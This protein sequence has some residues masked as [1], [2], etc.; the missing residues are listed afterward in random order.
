MG[1]AVAV[2]CD[3]RNAR[4]YSRAVGGNARALLK[5]LSLKHHELSVLIT[6]D[7]AIRELNRRFRGKDQATDVLSFP[8]IEDG[9][10]SAPGAGGHYQNMVTALGD[11][12]ISVDTAIRQASSLGVTP[13]TRMRTLLIHGVLHLLGYDHEKSRAEARRMF[14]LERELAAGL[15]AGEKRRSH[16]STAAYW[17]AEH[18]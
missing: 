9:L 5:L 14:L 8:Q 17:P 13:A 7:S 10:A 4:A 1:S 11:V 15:T 6:D 3:T 2:R 18:L 12:V 16:Y